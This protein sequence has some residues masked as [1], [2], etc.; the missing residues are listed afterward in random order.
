MMKRRPDM[1]GTVA[2]VV[3]SAFLPWPLS[4][5]PP[6]RPKYLRM[7]HV[8]RG[9]PPGNLHPFYSGYSSVFGGERPTPIWGRVRNTQA[10]ISGTGKVEDDAQLN[11]KTSTRGLDSSQAI[12]S[13]ACRN[14]LTT[15]MGG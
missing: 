6:L 12:M 8:E 11:R 14:L 7:G 15:E 9:L 13:F 10:S 2:C 3:A 1:H 4:S 5:L